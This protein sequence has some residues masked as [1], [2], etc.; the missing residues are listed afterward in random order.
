MANPTL[1][2][3]DLGHDVSACVAGV[4]VSGPHKIGWIMATMVGRAGGMTIET[5]DGQGIILNNSLDI[6][7]ARLNIG[8]GGVMAHGAAAA[9]EGID[10]IRARPKVG[11]QRIGTSCPSTSVAGVTGRPSGEIGATHQYCVGG[12]GVQRMTI[13]VCG[14]AGDT[15]AARGMT[16]GA[17]EQ[18][19]SCCTVT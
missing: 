2:I 16:D 15:L 3:M 14:M 8:R 12:R 9:M 7:I 5:T 18:S 11:K 4:T 19:S 13:E 1:G 10:T 17:A 6:G